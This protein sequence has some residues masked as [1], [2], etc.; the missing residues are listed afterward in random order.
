[1]SIGA[2]LKQ[3]G[4]SDNEV[5]QAA[6]HM[7]LGAP[8]DISLAEGTSKIV[9]SDKLGSDLVL[10]FA[11]GKTLLVRDFFAIG[12]DGDF[13]RLLLPNGE[14][15]ATGLMS[16]EPFYEADR[17]ALEPVYDVVSAEPVVRGADAELQSVG[18]GE[19]V[20]WSSPLLLAG[21]GLSLGA[22]ANF[23]TSSGDEDAAVA[24]RTEDLELSLAVSDLMGSEPDTLDPEEYGVEAAVSTP[25]PAEAPEGADMKEAAPAEGSA[26]GTFVSEPG[27]S[28]AVLPMDA[29][30]QD[31][32]SAELLTE[33]VG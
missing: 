9:A 15:F 26:E 11:D 4:S 31:G 24:A 13:S 6:S 5:A 1:M 30:F 3:R 25:D 19:T 33:F 8:A 14:V 32:L 12:P 2:T 16:P 17:E 10:R 18:L 27:M 23:L 28:P 20:D 7:S 21:A 22:G 29:E